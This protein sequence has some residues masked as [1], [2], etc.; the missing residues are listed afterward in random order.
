[1]GRTLGSV[2]EGRLNGFDLS[3]VEEL[4]S[5]EPVVDLDHADSSFSVDLS[6]PTGEYEPGDPAD[7]RPA[8][9]HHA[10]VLSDVP[11][12]T[13]LHLVSKI[14]QECGRDSEDKRIDATNQRERNYRGEPRSI[15]DNP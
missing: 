3:C 8:E 14:V 12:A 4:P 1:M 10:E 5:E 9:I 11:V 7:E 15:L 6:H 13:G 2:S